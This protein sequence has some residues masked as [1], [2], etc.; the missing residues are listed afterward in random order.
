MIF[1]I[2]I[3]VYLVFLVGISVYKSRAVRTQDDFMV[4]GRS[5][6][7]YF[8]VGT[9][10]C[11]WIG[12]GSLFGGAGRAFREGFSALWMSAGAWVGIAIVYFLAG[13][14]RK[15]AQYTVPDIL[16]T[17]Y[18]PAARILGT[19]AIIIA[20]LTIAS[21]Q[22]IGGGRLLS[23]LFPHLDPAVGQ[24]I[25]AGL[26]VL[27]TIMAGMMSIVTL[28]VFNGIMII[29][30]IIIAAPLTLSQAGGWSGLTATLP[31]Y[32]F[33]A[34][35]RLGILP[36]LGLFFPTFLLL[37]GESSMYQKFFSAKDA[38]SARKAV[39]GMIIGVVIIET[40]LDTTSIFGSGLY[41]NHP[42]FGGG[43]G[44]FTAAQQRN[45]ETILLQLARHNLPVVAGCLLLAGAV[46]IIFST[47]NTFLMVPSTNLA[48][49]IYQR[50]INP[51]VSEQKIIRFQR[52]MIIVLAI[53]AYIVSSFFVSIL[54]M[55]L[56]AYTMVG[57]AVTPALL[58]AFLWKRVTP[59]GGVASIA[60][61][62]LVTLIFGLLNSMGITHW[63]YD[64]IVYPAAI[65]S[66]FFLVVVSLRTP[67]SPREKWLPFVENESEQIQEP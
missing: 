45:T 30:S 27:Y 40:L 41:W 17:R 61:G 55:A 21:Y 26:V 42:D 20:Y 36:A 3:A 48:R 57:A 32:H 59:A 49:D 38:A 24:A 15:I 4:A 25:I 50:F 5:V 64:Y 14:V 56:Y 22:F 54:D 9:L 53:L 62:M 58:A 23:I 12:S 11:T 37:L 13:R 10:V 19:V 65:A 47:A 33:T 35:G 39:I 31:H 44:I 43:D 7:W 52:L 2:V 66:I 67:P 16:E 28:D 29:S 63:D 34:L 46:A 60:A 1:I 51:G 6:S 8:L 18:H